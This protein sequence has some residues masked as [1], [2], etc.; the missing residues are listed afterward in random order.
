MTR[1]RGVTL[2]EDQALRV[3]SAGAHHELEVA[4]QR[5]TVADE[6]RMTLRSGQVGY[7]LPPPPLFD[8]LLA[9]FTTKLSSLHELCR[10]VGIVNRLLLQEWGPVPRG[11]LLW[12][13][14]WSIVDTW[15][16]R[17]PLWPLA[18]PAPRAETGSEHGRLSLPVAAV[19]SSDEL[20]AD[21]G[22]GENLEAA[23]LQPACREMWLR[24]LQQRRWS[25]RWVHEMR[26]AI[27]AARACQVPSQACALIEATLADVPRASRRAPSLSASLAGSSLWLADITAKV[28]RRAACTAPTARGSAAIIRL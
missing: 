18:L 17:Q 4:F 7:L 20:F 26:T 12:P 1:R 22:L 14:P 10:D 15:A 6:P 19:G 11:H 13:M 2:G 24:F 9:R 5:D 25:D 8:R 23:I 27:R 28:R 3:L 21:G 16:L